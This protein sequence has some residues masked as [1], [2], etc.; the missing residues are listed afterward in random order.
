[1][2]SFTVFTEIKNTNSIKKKS[3]SASQ[4]HLTSSNDFGFIFVFEVKRQTQS[5]A[6]CGADF[7]GIVQHPRYFRSGTLVQYENRK[8]QLKDA[9]REDV[10]AQVWRA[11]CAGHCAIT[12]LGLAM[13]RN[14]STVLL[15]LHLFILP[16]H[17]LSYLL[18]LVFLLPVH[19]LIL[20]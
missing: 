7:V 12:K 18:F 11:A 14:T 4:L 9:E 16:H 6:F 19:P 15:L 1:M 2:H 17:S 5:A 8:N 10:N 13:R 20:P 3:F